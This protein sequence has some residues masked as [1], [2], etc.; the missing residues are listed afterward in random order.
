MNLIEVILKVFLNKN[1]NKI[2]LLYIYKYGK[3]K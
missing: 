2:I 1:K 3:S